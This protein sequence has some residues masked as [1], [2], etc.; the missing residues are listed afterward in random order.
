MSGKSTMKNFKA[1]LAEAKLPER[2]VEICLRGDLV[3]DHEALE[4]RLEAAER[5]SLH[6]MEGADVAQLADQIEQLQQEMRE[7]TYTFRLRA[8]PRHEYRALVQAHPPRR[9]EN[10]DPNEADARTGLNQDTF[11]PDLVR[12][13]AVDPELTEQEWAELLDSKLTDKQFETLTDVAYFLNRG[14]V[15]VPFSRAASRAKRASA[16]E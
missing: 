14:D 10:G 11:F 8:L 9:E 4:R 16:S 5:A 3:A 2:G 1:M 7:H 15:D 6:S 13:C 12:R